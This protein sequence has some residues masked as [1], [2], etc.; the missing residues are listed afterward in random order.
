PEVEAVDLICPEMDKHG[1]AQGLSIPLPGDGSQRLALPGISRTYARVRRIRPN[2]IVSA[3][4]GPYGLLG[5]YLSQKLNTDFCYGYHTQYDQLTRL[6]WKGLVGRIS[7]G[8]LSRM[9][10]FFMHRARVVLT[11]GRDMVQSASD[12]GAKQIRLVGTPLDP[13]LL[14]P[15][16]EKKQAGAGP[17]LFV[18]RLAAEK[19]I[20]LLIEAAE[21]LAD[22]PFVVAGTGPFRDVVQDAAARLDNLEYAGWVDRADLAD[23]LDQRCELLVLPSEMESFGTVAAEAMARQRMVLVSSRCGIADWP[24]LLPGLEIMEPG[25]NLADRIRKILDMPVSRR[26]EK[27]RKAR[28]CC[29]LFVQQTTSQWISVLRGGDP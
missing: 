1:Q 26:L 28:E 12:L 15:A 7:S 20:P 18:G 4:P 13:R 23:L 3:T 17:V 10:R 16:R 8:F 14:G 11:N 5:L 22:I 2:I 6:Y 21:Q 25:Q 19:N 29:R 24:E 9:E 27:S